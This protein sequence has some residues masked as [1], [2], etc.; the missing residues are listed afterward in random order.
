MW[1][2]QPFQGFGMMPRGLGVVTR[3]LLWMTIGV[4]VADVLFFPR[5][6]PYELS[7]LESLFA[8]SRQGIASGRIWQLVTYMFLH[9]GFLHIF[10]NM[11]GLYFFGSEIE[12][13]LGSRRFLWLY[14]G[15]GIIGGLGWLLLSVTSG[16]AVCIGASGAVFGV[17]GAFAAMYP[18]RQVTLLVFFV[19][20]VT[21]KA[22]TLALIIGGVSLLLLRSDAGGIAHAAHLGGGL[23]GYLV[24]LRW[25]GG[26]FQG[27]LR[28][29]PSWRVF[30]SDWRA[31]LRRGRFRV[32]SQ[33]NDDEAVDWD[34]VDRILMKV[35]SMGMGSLTPMERDVLDRAS[36]QTR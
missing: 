9:G 14:L 12:S 5:P 32:Y 29:M 20:P 36:R 7:Q 24:G 11:L 3:R 8:L 33:P 6:T 18:D 23:A 2:D 19:L 34:E 31:R 21:L 16:N 1:N 22:R 28:S 4:F 26:R 17:I 35:H 13:R 27:G 30:W 15:A 25:R 10:A